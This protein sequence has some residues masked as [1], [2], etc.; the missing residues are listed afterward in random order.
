LRGGR[1]A[2][3]AMP[4]TERAANPQADQPPETQPSQSDACHDG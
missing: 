3:L 2:T 4:T 1:R